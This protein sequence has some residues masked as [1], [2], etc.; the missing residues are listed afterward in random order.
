MKE[1]KMLRK[2]NV[3]ELERLDRDHYRRSDKMPLVEIGRASCR[4]RV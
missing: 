1:I 3:N 4:E 2:L